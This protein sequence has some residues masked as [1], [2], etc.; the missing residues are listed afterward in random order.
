MIISQMLTRFTQTFDFLVTDEFNDEVFLV[1]ITILYKNTFISCVKTKLVH[2]AFIINTFE[3]N[4]FNLSV[5]KL[6]GNVTF[7]K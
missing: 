3:L 1:S 2:L 4:L 6:P 5:V 7:Y